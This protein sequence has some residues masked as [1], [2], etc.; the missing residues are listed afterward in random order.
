MV[1]CTAEMRL[2][3]GA[4]PVINFRT[5]AVN[6]KASGNSQAAAADILDAPCSQRS[7][8]ANNGNK[9]VSSAVL[10]TDRTEPIR[11]RAAHR[12]GSFEHQMR[13]ILTTGAMEQMP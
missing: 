4:A 12:D 11:T 5:Q 13:N 2:G 7:A 8:G 3:T 6:I 10:T 1:G 9:K